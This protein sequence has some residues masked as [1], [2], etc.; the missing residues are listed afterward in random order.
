MSVVCSGGLLG[1]LCAF[2]GV[3]TWVVWLV[4]AIGYVC[5]MFGWC[6]VGIWLFVVL[7][8]CWFGVWLGL[9]V[10]GFCPTLL[11]GFGWLI[12]C[13]L[14]MLLGLLFDLIFVILVLLFASA[15]WMVV[16]GNLGL[17]GVALRLVG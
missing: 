13:C 8:P 15:L 11:C 4:L 5:C 6:V 10:G 14:L 17:V 3:F 12:G 2:G 9:L 16:F 7:I 1:G